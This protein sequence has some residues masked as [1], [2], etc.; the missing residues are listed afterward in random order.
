MGAERAVWAVRTDGGEPWKVV[1][2]D[3]PL[4]SPDGRWVLY[5]RG[6]QIYRVPVDRHELSV[7]AGNPEGPLFLGYGT[8]SNPRW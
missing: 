5:T 6:G 2:A 8:N 1:V 4:L 7:R 3:N